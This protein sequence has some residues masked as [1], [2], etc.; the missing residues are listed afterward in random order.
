LKNLAYL[1]ST[2]LLAACSLTFEFTSMQIDYAIETNNLSYSFSKLDKVV[3]NLSLR[4]PSG[5]IY[6]FLGPNGAGKTT[7]MKLICGMLPGTY[8]NISLLGRRLDEA[9]PEVFSEVGTLIEMPSLYLNLTAY[10]N[11]RHLCVL[12]GL[13]RSVIDPVLET[14][15]LA[16]TGKKLVKAF[17]L[18]MKQRLGIATAIIHKPRLLML[19]EPVNGLDPAGIVE[20]RNLLIRLKEEHGITVFISSHLLAE[21]ERTCDHIGIIHRGKLRYQGTMHDLTSRPGLSKEV[22]FLVEDAPAAAEKLLPIFPGLRVLNQRSLQLNIDEQTPVSEINRKFV[23]LS[24][25]VEGIDVKKGLEEWFM[26]LTNEK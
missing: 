5:S 11:L 2:A 12:K 20:I 16:K 25:P 13:D 7:T 24:I 1:T 21:I 3:D 17:S 10:D 23:E 14:V 26:N 9:V 19:D 22:Q 4:V 15:G 6:G 8:N 18:G